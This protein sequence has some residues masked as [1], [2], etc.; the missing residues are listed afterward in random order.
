[1]KK[2]KDTSS[3]DFV[4][5]KEVSRVVLD[6]CPLDEEKGGGKVSLRCVRA[7]IG[8]FR[9]PEDL[10]KELAAV[11]VATKRGCQMLADPTGN[12]LLI[13]KS[14][15]RALA[16]VFNQRIFWRR[17]RLSN[18]S[19]GNTSIKQTNFDVTSPQR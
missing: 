17:R 5:F 7:R 2:K 12:F 10:R 14:H 15:N 19:C 8:R 6:I 1:M 9:N 3:F 11:A 16:F 18:Q 4:A 13:T